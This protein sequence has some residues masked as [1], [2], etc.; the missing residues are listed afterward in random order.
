MGKIDHSS[1]SWKTTK[2]RMVLSEPNKTYAKTIDKDGLTRDQRKR[3][4]D[5]KEAKTY[6][7]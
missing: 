7:E 6:G 4:E 3:I 5:I 1:E 2:N